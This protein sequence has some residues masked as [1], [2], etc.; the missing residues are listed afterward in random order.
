MYNPSH[1]EQVQFGLQCAEQI[2]VTPLSG[3]LKVQ[4]VFSFPR[5]QVHFTHS[6]DL[7]PGAPVY[8]DRVADVDNLVKF[9]LD[10]MIG[11]V[12]IDDCQVMELHAVKRYSEGRQGRTTVSVETM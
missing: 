9:A 10:A 8:Y 11:Y 2:D 5:P 3:P 4:L 7:R 6:G 1:A 12:Y